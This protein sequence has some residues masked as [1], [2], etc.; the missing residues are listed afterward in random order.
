VTG[1]CRVAHFEI[2]DRFQAL[3][4]GR[5]QEGNALA[6]ERLWEIVNSPG[7]EAWL[8]IQS[9][10]HPTD[11]VACSLDPKRNLLTCS[12]GPAIPSGPLAFHLLGEPVER[13]RRGEWEG[14]L[15]QALNLILDQLI[16]TE[17]ED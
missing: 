5:I 16:W 14:T 12:P 8:V 11:L 2:W 6:G 9:T 10:R 1:A 4:A 13:L 3:A 7:I 15:D 17:E